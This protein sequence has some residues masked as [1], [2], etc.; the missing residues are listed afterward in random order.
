MAVYGKDGPFP[1]F[2]Q[3]RHYGGNET[4]SARVLS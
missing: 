1:M 2:P 3:E 4:P